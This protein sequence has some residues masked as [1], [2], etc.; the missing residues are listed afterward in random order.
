MI[1]N[2]VDYGKTKAKVQNLG[3]KLEVPNRN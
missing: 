1:A 2:F 3:A